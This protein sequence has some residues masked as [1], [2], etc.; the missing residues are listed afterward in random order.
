AQSAIATAIATLDSEVSALGI[1][2][3][4][5]SGTGADA[6]QVHIHFTPT[7]DIGGVNQGVLGA[8]SPG[9]QIALIDG[10]NWYFG[11]DS[12]N[13]SKDQFDFQSVVIHELGHALGLGESSDPSS[14][15]Y[16]YLNARQVQHS[17]S[18]NDLNAIRQELQVGYGQISSPPLPD[19]QVFP[20]ASLADGT[21]GS[22]SVPRLGRDGAVDLGSVPGARG[23]LAVSD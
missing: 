22:A 17:L 14:V 21:S 12:N 8:F 3:R 10:W 2:L 5:L 16:L 6:A 4:Q 13:I 20:I 23:A 9:G 7:S 18:T 11:S 1:H 15:M 19:G